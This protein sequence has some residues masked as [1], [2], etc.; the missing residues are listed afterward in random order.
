[1]RNGQPKFR[2]CLLGRLVPDAPE[3]TLITLAEFFPGRAL[4]RVSLQSSDLDDLQRRINDLRGFVEAGYPPMQ[5]PDLQHL[6]GRLFEMVVQGSVRDM[7]FEATGRF[8]ADAGFASQFMPFEIIVEDYAVAGWPWEYMFNPRRREFLCQEFHP[9]SRDIF[10]RTPLIVRERAKGKLRILLIVG[11]LPQDPEITPE[12]EIEHIQKVFSTYLAT[13]DVEIQPIQGR[14]AVDVEKRL[15][16]GDYDI[17]HFYGHAAY[18]AARDE[19]YLKLD[20]GAD[21][22]P[23]RWYASVF[24]SALAR[25]NIGL[26]FL[27]A[28]ETGRASDVLD[29]SS[30]AGAL[31]A[32]GVP[33]VI[34]TQ[35]TMPDNAS[36]K[37]SSLVYNGLVLGRPL[38]DAMRDGRRAMI[39]AN[40]SR[41]ID[42]GIPVLYASEPQ[43]M[44]FRQPRNRRLRD[45]SNASGTAE[46]APGF[47]I[48]LGR[49]ASDFVVE[50]T[51]SAPELTTFSVRIALVDLDARVTFLSDLAQRAN[52]CQSYYHFQVAYPPM[53]AGAV[54]RAQDGNDTAPQLILPHMEEY[55]KD[56]PTRFAA[57]YVL[58]LTRCMVA[59]VDENTR[60]WNHFSSALRSNPKIAVISTYGMREYARQAQRSFASGVFWHCLGELMMMDERW[61]LEAHEETVGC[62]LDYC[63]QRSDVVVGL[64]LRRF[65]HA[66]CR[67]RIKDPQQLEAIDALAGL[68][69]EDERRIWGWR[70]VWS[71]TIRQVLNLKQ[72]AL[73]P[74]V[75]HF[76][77]GTLGQ[78]NINDSEDETINLLR[79][80][81][82]G[83]LED[84]PV[85]SW[86]PV[87]TTS[88]YHVTVT[89]VIDPD[90]MQEARLRTTRWTPARPLQRGAEYEWWIIVK[91]PQG[92]RES[93]I[94]RFMVIEQARAEEVQRAE[95]DFAQS[96]VELGILYAATGL[97]DDAEQIWAKSVSTDPLVN[98][99]LAD[100]R[101]QRRQS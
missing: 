71:A 20:R 55:L 52:Q 1:M 95:R 98:S 78:E 11:V 81:A 25:H 89:N 53:P 45:A 65:D 69:V 18:D 6:G 74:R 96:P 5:M 34:A 28:C 15:Q 7:F 92:D 22:V 70:D 57:D 54:L 43:M 39:Y 91:T 64:Q 51:L 77:S 83:T 66:V 3:Q 60:F 27:N 93:G 88:Y 31:L 17:V 26:V 62:L 59:G 87:P 40:G 14:D 38:T 85:F 30:V 50:R 35:F 56:L 19:G 32:K 101:Q 16:E 49:A 10:E 58:C 44:V 67:G 68:E 37:F 42:W 29:R 47:G 73:P 13:E 8:Y 79:P 84:R 2:L 36:H 33:A 41:F 82:T 86:K 76:A 61:N 80:V 75:L 48:P 4:E 90:D 99:L 63:R 72:V 94:A 97:L 46:A 9:I 100:L 21:R 23:D 24:A 12:D